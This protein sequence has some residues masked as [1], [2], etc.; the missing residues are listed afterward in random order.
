[1]TFASLSDCEV[2]IVNY[3]AGSLLI[4]CVG[5]ALSQDVGHV[6]V[7]DNASSDDSLSVL[8]R[9]LP[10]ESRLRIIR[11]GENLGFAKAC[12][13]GARASSGRYLLFLNPDATLEEG[14]LD[15]MF[16][17]LTSGPDIGMV[18]GV[19][20]NPDGTEQAGGRRGF[21]TPRRAFI[22]AFGLSSLVR[23]FPRLFSDFLLHK[24]PLPRAPV[25][26]EAISGACMLVKREAMEDVGFWDEAYFLHCE[27][28]DLCMRFR[29]KGWKILFVPDAHV[30][31][32]RGT[33][34]RS[35]PIFVEWH[36]HKGMMRF[37]RKFFRHQYPGV[38][39]GLVAVGVWL[40]FGL[41]AGYYTLK[42]AKR[43]L[44]RGRG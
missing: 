29:Q 36:K 23:I 26:V 17:V 20:C 15:R 44:R 21:P 7:V 8:E 9:T 28:L 41:V 42:R 33:C 30:T 25:P 24:E 5:S 31:H 38:L 2:I 27:D 12:N 39:M 14:A 3:N 22:R 1:M 18:G 35:R 32:H 40:R 11:N 19:L 4:A 43:V 13:V 6:V 34:S 10:E 16:N 37:Y